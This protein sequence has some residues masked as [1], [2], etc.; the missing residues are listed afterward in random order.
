MSLFED[1]VEL[2]LNGE[3]L[4]VSQSYEIKSSLVVQPSA[5][6]LRLGH[7]GT[8]K[9]LIF[10]YPPGTPFQLT[11]NGNP[12]FSGFTDGFSTD[13]S[14]GATE[15]TLNGRDVTAVLHD[16]YILKETSFSESSFLKL[17][18]RALLNTSLQK[19]VISSSDVANIKA[20]TGVDVRVIQELVPID[21][22]ATLPPD[23]PTVRESKRSVKRSLKCEAGQT[24]YQFLKDQYDRAGLFLWG[25][26]NGEFVLGVPNANQEPT[27]RIIRERGR[28]VDGV[29]VKSHS[30]SV[31]NM[32]RY[33]KAIVYGRGG[34]RNFG[35]TKIVGEFVDEGMSKLL[36]GP[37]KKPIV[38]H[39]NTIKTVKQ[40]QFRARR[41]IAEANRD[42]WSLSYKVAG[43]S[44]M[45][46][47]GKR[48]VW[49]RN[50]MVDVQDDELGINRPLFLESVTYRRNPQTETELT[51]MRPEDLVFA[52]E[53]FGA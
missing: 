30:G 2:H 53:L 15:V 1:K 37:D 42:G 19:F 47:L 29:T 41:I 21:E 10:K 25:S 5:F 24:W 45:S 27:Y 46:L 44:V 16:T 35:R 33:T 39:D 50:T 36:G 34:G 40:A 32:R 11:I 48:A 7:G 4:L 6:S 12:L 18:E 38:E 14:G 8:A 49:A 13:D 31:S 23:A 43:H 52:A 22:I 17:T 26:G 28:T 9:E 20:I 3:T 51:F